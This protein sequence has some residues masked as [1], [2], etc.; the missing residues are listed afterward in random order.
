MRT[1]FKLACAATALISAGSASGQTKIPSTKPEKPL[2]SSPGLDQLGGLLQGRSVSLS[3]AVGIALLT[4]R[5]LALANANLYVSQGRTSE[6]YAALN[7]TLGSA[8]EVVRLNEP[9]TNKTLTVLDPRNFNSPI[10]EYI[11]NENIQQKLVG[12]TANLPIDISGTLHVATEQ[13]K[14]EQLGYRLDVDRT[15]NQIVSD[16]KAAF[17]D[18]LR[19]RALVAVATEDL[20]NSQDRLKEAESRLEARVVTKFDVLRAQTDV[21]AA[22]QNVI[23]AKNTLDT[24]LAVLNLTIGIKVT[25]P[26]DVVETGAVQQPDPTQV[27][28]VQSAGNL[29]NVF[30]ADLKEAL[31]FRP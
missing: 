8:L 18:V 30:D 26:L 10:G 31:G 28:A 29:G 17:Y 12:V 15:R 13:A 1:T 14:F 4:N 22:Q 24:D 19:A 5:A 23:V 21:A 11:D 25:A 20:Q 3:E 7:P 2:T 9:V 27:V 6:A 16:V